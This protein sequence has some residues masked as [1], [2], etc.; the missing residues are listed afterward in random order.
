MEKELYNSATL[1][2]ISEILVSRNQ[3]IATAESVTAGHLQSALSLAPNAMDFFQG[4]LTAYNLQQKTRFLG[5]DPIKAVPCDCVSQSIAVTM[6]QS[7][8]ALFK[9]DW[10]IGI[11]GYASPVPE[12]N[13][14]QLF[15]CYAICYGKGFIV[16]N[17]VQAGDGSPLEISIFYTNHLLKELTEIL[18]E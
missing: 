3:T 17:T 16:S 9:C 10:G 15:A 18:A 5:V 2:K 11:T 13:V 6:A 7:V 14:E 1:K 12:K 8:T 4:G